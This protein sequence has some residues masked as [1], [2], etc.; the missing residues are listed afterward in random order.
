MT[1]LV[2]RLIARA[3]ADVVD[4]CGCPEVYYCSQSREIECPLHGGFDVCCHRPWL[5]IRARQP[6][7][8]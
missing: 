1:D 4:D 5:H 6:R 2:D 7:T 8:W 3:W